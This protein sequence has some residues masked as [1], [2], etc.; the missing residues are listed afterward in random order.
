MKRS[1]IM[2]NVPRSIVMLSVA[3]LCFFALPQVVH[4]ESRFFVEGTVYC[5]TCRAQ[6]IT[7][8]SEYIE[9]ARV[10]LEC[11]DREGGSLTY[12]IEGETNANGLYSLPVDGDREDQI[13]EVVLVKSNKPGCEEIDNSAFVRKGARVSITA[14]NGLASP[15]RL[16]NP[17]G[18]LK[19]KPLPECDKVLKELGLVPSELM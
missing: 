8:I 14:N 3:A 6:F 1:S 10:R 12:S 5:D 18:F 16:A 19:D 11:R 7:K 4:G 17:L 9:G 15:V 2:E 13:C